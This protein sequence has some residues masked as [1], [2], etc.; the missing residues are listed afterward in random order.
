M[1]NTKKEVEEIRKE[2][3]ELRTQLSKPYVA[4]FTIE[5][6]ASSRTEAPP[7]RYICR[8]CGGIRHFAKDCP[9]PTSEANQ[10]QIEL[11]RRLMT[12]PIL[13]LSKNDGCFV[14]DTDASDFGLDTALFQRQTE[15]SAEAPALKPDQKLRVSQYEERVIAY[16]LRT[17]SKAES[18]YETT[19]KELL[20]VVFGLK[21]FKS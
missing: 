3:A 11:K 5:A 19:R 10:G 4:R 17:L 2:M 12:R 20:T 7:N 14:L 13:A 18:K 9:S 15:A 6:P 1:K 21:Q 8:L 16:A